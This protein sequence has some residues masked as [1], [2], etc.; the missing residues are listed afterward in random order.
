VTEIAPVKALRAMPG[1]PQKKRARD[2]SQTLLILDITKRFA[3]LHFIKPRSAL[4]TR[5][6]STG[7]GMV[8]REAITLDLD[9]FHTVVK[10]EEG[11]TNHR[12][13]GIFHGSR[14]IGND[15]GRTR[16]HI[17]SG[18]TFAEAS[19]IRLVIQGSI[20]QL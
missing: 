10:T 15:S 19:L 12:Q 8:K 4:V 9:T 20:G 16:S 3:T 14:V 5:G 2:F 7:I 13:T 18:P 6:C 1:A 17:Q 11:S